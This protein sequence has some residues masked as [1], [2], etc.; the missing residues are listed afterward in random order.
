MKK[1]MKNFNLT[2]VIVTLMS[3]IVSSLFSFNTVQAQDKLTVYMPSPAGLAEKL[4]AAFSEETGIE[5]DLFQGTTGEITARLEAESANPIAD[6]VI[7]ASW[8]DGLNM[9]NADQIASYEPAQRDLIVDGWIDDENTLFGYSASAVG[10][11]Y[12]TDIFSEIDV[13]W[14]G[15]TSEEFKDELAIPDPEKSGAAKDFVSGFVEANGWDVFEGMA[16]NGLIVPGANKAALESVMTGEVG[17]LVGGVDYNAYKSIEDGEPLAIYYPAGGTIVN[18]RPA[19]IM[20]TAPNPEAAQQFIDF[21]FTDAAQQLVAEAYLL[22]GRSDIEVTN[23]A[24]LE[25]I[26]QITPD[27]TAMME[28]AD[29]DAARINELAN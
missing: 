14:D 15:F 12:N 24:S 11:V 16:N 9:K 25:E 8:T 3:L 21:L 1:S 23:R 20:K 4:V 2:F 13:D 22:P 6:V 7:L 19:M 18:P 26:P 28:H 17:V 27:W 29:E 5:V 10:V